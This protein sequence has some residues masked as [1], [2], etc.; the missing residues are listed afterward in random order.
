MQNIVYNEYL[1][2]V[3]GEKVAKD[4][5]NGLTTPAEGTKYDPNVDPSISNE[6]ATAAFRFGH[7]MI[8]GLIKR[9]I[10]TTAAYEKSYKLRDN[11]F[12]DGVENYEKGK[13]P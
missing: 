8:Q 9:Y 6:F 1:P 3:L 2:V 13:T 10:A 12:D 4:P 11:F 7:S 5:K